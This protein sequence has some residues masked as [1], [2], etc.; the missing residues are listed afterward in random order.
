[1]FLFDL[2]GSNEELKVEGSNE[3]EGRNNG[4]NWDGKIDFLGKTNDSFLEVWS[5][6]FG[7]K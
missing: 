4:A 6:Y 7:N 1:M 5:N 3:D 2:E